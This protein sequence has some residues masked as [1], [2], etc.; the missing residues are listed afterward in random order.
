MAS[1]LQPRTLMSRDPIHR[2]SR[3]A[4][5][6]TVCALIAAAGACSSRPPTVKPQVSRNPIAADS[7]VSVCLHGDTT[8]IQLLNRG[9]GSRRD[10]RWVVSPRGDVVDVASGRVV[11][12]SLEADRFSYRAMIDQQRALVEKMTALAKEAG[13]PVPPDPNCHEG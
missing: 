2:P 5:A 13:Q 3:R 1:G 8:A 9:T 10:E 12:D 4:A 11:M 7:V 6:A